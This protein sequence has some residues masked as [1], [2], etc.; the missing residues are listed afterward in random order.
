MTGTINWNSAEHGWFPLRF[1]RQIYVSQR[2]D[3]VP[4]INMMLSILIKLLKVLSK[5]KYYLAED[6]V[7]NNGEH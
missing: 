7:L 3:M 5:C 6:N 2:F 4:K 1:N